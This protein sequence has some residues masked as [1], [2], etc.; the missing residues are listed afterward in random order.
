MVILGSN[1]DLL[2][3]IERR[4][5][6]N[7]VIVSILKPENISPN[8]MEIKSTLKTLGEEKGTIDG[9]LYLACNTEAEGIVPFLFA[10]HLS[11]YFHGSGHPSRKA[12]IVVMSLDGAFGLQE[13]QNWQ[14]ETAALTG[15]V[16]SLHQEWPWVYTKVIDLSPTFNVEFAAESIL[17]EWL[18]ADGRSVEVGIT[19]QSRHTIDFE[20]MKE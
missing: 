14:P 8:D 11:R 15:L 10:K 16:K 19:E 12:F 17:S 4:F 7:D 5:R 1:D 20:M 2:T 9:F 3:A 18:D 13:Y 6:H